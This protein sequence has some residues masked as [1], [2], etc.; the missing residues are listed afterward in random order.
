MSFSAVILAGGKSSRMGC[1]KALLEVDGQP[2]LARQIQLVR[3]AGAEEVFISGRADTDYAVFNCPV[4]R[5]RLTDVGPLAG[6]E[7]AL[8][9]TTS[10]LLLVLAVDMPEMSAVFLQRLASQ[11]AGGCG[12]IPCVGGFIEPLA[13]FYPK[14]ASSLLEELGAPASLPAERS[15]KLPAGMPALPERPA[16]TPGAKLFAERCV[17]SGLATFVDFPGTD[18]HFFANWNSPADVASISAV[19]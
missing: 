4:L 15:G 14:A 2:L 16:K 13:A 19:A 3:E 10:P 1:D 18:A 5:D 9:A 8:N 7:A 11:C 17:A 12:V 6:I